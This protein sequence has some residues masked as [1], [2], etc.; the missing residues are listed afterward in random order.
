MTRRLRI[1]IRCSVQ[2]ES[3]A[4]CA[5]GSLRPAA[6][7]RH[8]ALLVLSVLIVLGARTAWSRLHQNRVE[9]PPRVAVMPFENLTGDPDR[10]YL[11]DGLTEETAASLGQ[12][13]DSTQAMVIGRVSTKGYKGTRKSS[14][15]SDGSCQSRT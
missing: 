13:I 11:A 10:E 6:R 5:T 8:V 1:K 9:N 15:R 14:Q 7:R 2:A 3:D 4:I 12:I